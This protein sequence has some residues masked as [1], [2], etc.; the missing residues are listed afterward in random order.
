[1]I[2]KEDLRIKKTKNA[3]FNAFFSMMESMTFEEVTV[4]ELCERAEIRRATFYKH[5]SDKLDFLNAVTKQLRVQFD[6]LRWRGDVSASEYYVA[7]AKRIVAFLAEHENVVDNLMRSDLMPTIINVITEQNYIDTAERLKRS[8]A[9]GVRLKASAEV[10]A[11][12]CSGGVA[13]II[14]HWLSE[15]KKKSSDELAEEIGILVSQLI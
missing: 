7:Y 9:G 11:M 15:G 13:H 12:M 1:M 6:S 5:Y 2:K 8:K 3:L 4:N 10:T 14:L